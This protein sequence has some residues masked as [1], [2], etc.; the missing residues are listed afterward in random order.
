MSAD[1]SGA[2]SGSVE[3]FGD[4]ALFFLMTMPHRNDVPTR[5]PWCP[6][7]HDDP[8]FQPTIA[9]VADLAVITPVVFKG[10]GRSG[11]HLARIEKI[12]APLAQRPGTFRGI[13][14][15]LYEINVSQKL[16]MQ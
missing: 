12:D 5:C 3:V 15:D 6:Y 2:S 16:R 1:H 13:A 11:E 4:F 8:P 9:L 10:Q 14:G 7:D